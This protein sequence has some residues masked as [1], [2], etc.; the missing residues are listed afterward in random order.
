MRDL[1][2][3]PR[4]L[5]EDTLADIKQDVDTI[6]NRLQQPENNRGIGYLA[7][8]LIDRGQARKIRERRLLDMLVVRRAIDARMG[9]I[10]GQPVSP[11]GH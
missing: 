9:A 4:P 7:L 11:Q 1:P 8:R 10:P 2:V 5:D 3:T 6:I